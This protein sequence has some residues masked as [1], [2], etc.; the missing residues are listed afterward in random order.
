MVI[1]IRMK[2]ISRLRNDEEPVEVKRKVWDV[3]PNL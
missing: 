2:R 1:Q 3:P